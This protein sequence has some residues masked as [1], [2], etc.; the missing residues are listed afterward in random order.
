M[1]VWNVELNRTLS[2]VR[3]V[4]CFCCFT[5]LRYSDVARLRVCDVSEGSIGIVTQKT[6]APLTIEL[7]RWSREIL[8]R[9]AEGRESNDKA[10]PVFAN[11]T[12]NRFLKIVGELAGLDTLITTTYFNGTKRI[13]KTVPKWQ[14]LT[15]HVARRTFVVQSLRLGIAPAVVMKWTGHSDYKAMKPYIAIVD[16]LKVESMAKFDT[17]NDTPTKTPTK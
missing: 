3:D 15:F 10:L 9:H 11:A 16:S 17:L 14:L 1:A 12:I 13:T 5:G 2:A 8:Q 6:S 4:F 7:N